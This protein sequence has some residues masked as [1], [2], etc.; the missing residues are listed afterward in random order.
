[1]SR[2]ALFL[3]GLAVALASPATP[4]F[5][6]NDISYLSAGGSGFSC[7]RTAPCNDAGVAVLETSANGTVVCLDS[8]DFNGATIDKSITI[9]CSGAPATMGL[10]IEGSGIVVTVRGVRVDVGH[11]INFIAGASLTM[12]NCLFTNNPGSGVT[13]LLFDPVSAGAQLVVT[14]SLFTN[15]GSGTGGAIVIRPQPGGTAQ[16]VLSRVTVSK[17]AFGIAADGS[18][19]TGGINLTITDSVISSNGQDGIVATTSSGHAPIGVYVKNSKSANN[20]FGIRSLGPNVTVRVSNSSVIGNATGLAF[21]SGGALLS[22]GN[23]DVQ[24]NGT[25][26]AFS[27]SVPQQ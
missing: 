20:A 10:T 15:L 6:T 14:D 24:A 13:G 19:S 11:I 3:A 23:N 4:A 21:G 22:F 7:T 12:E 8:S 18:N 16:V 17:N 1:M 26:G 9:D 5:A 2:S 25:N 27:G